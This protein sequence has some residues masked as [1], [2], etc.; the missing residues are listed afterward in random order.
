M[1]AV[2]NNEATR[3]QP[4]NGDRALGDLRFRKLIP[5]EAW[6]GLVPAIRKRFTKCLRGGASAVYQG[7][8]IETR[9]NMWGHILAQTLRLF[10]APLPLETC[11]GGTAAIVTVTEAEHGQGQYWTRQYNRK[12]GFPQVIHST[13][14]F[15]GETG[16]EECVGHG[17]GMTL[18]VEANET[19]LNFVSERYFVTLL[20][21]R[22]Y[23]PDALTPGK[24]IVGHHDLGHASFD[25]TLDLVHPLF[26]QLL[27]QRA[28]FHDTEQTL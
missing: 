26:G 6:A 1:L 23:L 7:A 9:M 16:L 2:R 8:V 17:I 5:A 14:T 28:T 24:L 21:K 19:H 27:H 15:A 13:K 25:F 18:R 12:R 3:H 4:I 11:T 20:G 10:G 22:I